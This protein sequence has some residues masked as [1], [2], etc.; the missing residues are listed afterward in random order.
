M[1]HDGLANLL[2]DLLDTASVR[3]ASTLEEPDE[4]AGP[5]GPAFDEDV[6]AQVL[7]QRRLNVKGAAYVTKVGIG[8]LGVDRDRAESLMGKS[9]NKACTFCKKP[10]HD[11][12]ELS[13]D[14]TMAWHK[15]NFDGKAGHAGT[16]A[17]RCRVLFSKLGSLGVGRASRYLWSTVGVCW[18]GPG[19]ITI[20][21]FGACV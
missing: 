14:V 4:A 13:P 8:N 11:A 16:V 18:S 6:R 12:D 5:T 20:H 2:G 15:P 9:Y 17:G 19:W 21:L 7:K 3:S 1:E 10:I